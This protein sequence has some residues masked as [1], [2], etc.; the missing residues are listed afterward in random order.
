MYRALPTFS[1]KSGQGAV[2]IRGGV[3]RGERE[4][5][6]PLHEKLQSLVVLLAGQEVDHSGNN[7]A[8]D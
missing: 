7:A 3:Y 8:P 5:A 1:V 4:L 6:E 2:Q